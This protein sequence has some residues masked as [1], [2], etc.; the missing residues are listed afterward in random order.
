MQFNNLYMPSLFSSRIVEHEVALIWSYNW[1]MAWLSALN[2]VGYNW[3]T[4]WY[5]DTEFMNIICKM[6]KNIEPI[7]Q[8]IV[9]L[10]QP[11]NNTIGAYHFH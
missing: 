10:S 4:S 1:E 7:L 6:K 9:P 2:L 5:M 3:A 8:N 11:F